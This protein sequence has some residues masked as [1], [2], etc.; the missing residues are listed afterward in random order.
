MT[1]DPEIPRET[2]GEKKKES[3]KV[4]DEEE[5]D[6]YPKVNS[7]LVIFADVKS[8]SPL[9]VINK[10]VNMVAP[11]TTT[12]YLKWSQTAITFDQSDHSWEASVGGRP[13][14]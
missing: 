5:D 14:C 8:K 11:T 10:E 12:T 13:S 6:G 2:D 3:D 1:P 4:V 9:K 7:T